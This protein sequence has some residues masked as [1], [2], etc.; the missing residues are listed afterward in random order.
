MRI[1]KVFSSP[2]KNSPERVEPY[3]FES[4]QGRE[5]ERAMA[6]KMPE[7]AGL[8][9]TKK[10]IAVVSG[11]GGVGK[12]NFALNL[13]IE[14]GRRRSL[15]VAL[16]D[17]DFGMANIDVLLGVETRLNLTNVIEEELSLREITLPVSEKVWLVPGGSGIPSLASLDDESLKRIMR[18][19]KTLDDFVDV[20]IIDTGAGI[21]TSVRDFSMASDTVVLVTTPEPTALKDA[22]GMVKSLVYSHGQ[23]VLK[24]KELFVVINMAFS[25]E[26]A[27]KSAQRLIQT[28]RHFLGIELRLLG[29]I[30]YDLKI[31]KSVK[32]RTPIARL[33]PENQTVRRIRAMVDVLLPLEKGPVLHSV[34][35][36]EKDTGPMAKLLGRILKK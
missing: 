25:S 8:C 18:Q 3:S 6:G 21:H 10:S 28:C 27:Q 4:I 17:A 35:E 16:M 36:E 20:M 23:D 26:E 29:V 12:S 15:P 30:P 7:K 31:V 32:A 19:L 13:A 22:Y 2:D 1:G 33:Y 11:K 14:S 24:S 34:Q 9:K 5:L